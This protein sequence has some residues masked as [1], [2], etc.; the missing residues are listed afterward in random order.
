[1]YPEPEV[2][3]LRRR[4]SLDGRWNFLP[5]PLQQYSPEILTGLHGGRAPAPEDPGAVPPT[6]PPHLP[7][8]PPTWRSIVV[9]GTW[10]AQFDDLR[11]D[12]STAWY[13]FAFVLPDLAENAG[14]SSP[15][16]WYL[17][18]GAVDYYATVWLNGALLGDHEGGYLPFEFDISSASRPGTS[19]ELL[20]RVVD[21]SAD[22][23]STRFNF[24]EIP[25]GKQSWYG[26]V[27]GIWQSVFV[28]ARQEIHLQRI[29]VT[30]EPDQRR[31]LVRMELN[32]PSS[33][34]LE[35]KLWLTD[36]RGC[37]QRVTTEIESGT[38]APVVSIS[39]EHPLLWEPDSPH[40]YTLRVEL[41]AGLDSEPLD[42]LETEF[43][44]RTIKSGPDGLLRLNHR[45]LYLRGALDQDYY[46]LTNYTSFSDAELAEQFAR[47]RAMGLNCLRVHVKVADPRYYA[48]ADRAGMLI[49]TELPNWERLTEAAKLRADETLRGMVER[50]W[51]HPS[52]VIRTI[53][54][55]GWGV[56]LAVNPDDRAWLA[57]TFHI[58][59]DLDPTRLVVGNSPC[60]T[61]FHVVT[62]IEDFHNYYSLPDH[63][64]QWQSWVQSFAAR[65]PW[66]FAHVYEGI[67]A[68]RQ[69]T[70]DPWAPTPRVAAPEIRRLGT[71]AMVVSE[72]GNWGLPDIA[73]LREGYGGEPWWFETG[74]EWGDGVAYPHGIEMRYKTFHLDRVFP[75]LGDLTAASQRMQFTALKYEIEQIRQHPSIVGYIITEFTDTHWEANGL[76][77]LFRNPKAFY[78]ALPQINA[79]DAI[80]P[81]WDRIA[82]WEGD[83]CEVRLLLSHYSDLDLGSCSLDW[84]LDLTP[85]IRGT[86]THIHAPQGQLVSL[87]TVVLHAGQLARSTRARLQ[88]HLRTANGEVVTSN[89][90]ELY[91]FCRAD[92]APGRHRLYVPEPD[93]RRILEECGFALTD[94]LT[95]ADLVVARTMTDALRRHVERGGKVVWLAEEP[96]SQQTYLGNLVIARRRERSWQG[97]WINNMNWIRP[98]PMFPNIPTGGTV[99]FAF[100]DLIPEQVIVGLSPRHF[101]GDVHAGLFVG[102][103]H[104]VVALIAERRMGEGHLLISTFHLSAH[105]HT[106]PVAMV[107]LHDLVEYVAGLGAA[108]LAA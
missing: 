45:M 29:R 71:E 85:P 88:F 98:H 48:A 28:E 75:T 54:N 99:D 52:I 47:A 77:D 90:Q 18:F 59:K 101:A 107:M 67:E 44:M 95:T 8:P 82:F 40:L 81:S 61:N 2:K 63:Y 33:C 1:M 78:D 55:E 91:F 76:L 87:G 36:P 12:A 56:N 68:W 93:L 27:S 17:H 46:P 106:H 22:G 53:I 41:S 84:E 39:V 16:H 58:L 64:R 73:K 74:L 9:P 30:P 97:D 104:H 42:V 32:R 6:F 89:H 80:V 11:Q 103:L 51:N 24:A 69:F 105:L 35:A 92:G 96:D 25:H 72:F 19:N 57:A 23:E 26:P 49:W 65:P 70:S 102:W 31:A 21:T 62:D 10:Q 50:D 15:P 13:R 38:T 20:V 3:V 14:P 66:T 94:D 7:G 100:A 60:F 37:H 4:I 43:G 79:A 34:S 5:D 83:R 86:I 108:R